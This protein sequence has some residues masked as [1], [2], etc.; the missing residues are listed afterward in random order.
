MRHALARGTR[1]AWAF[2]TALLAAVLIVACN[3][4]IPI[5]IAPVLSLGTPRPTPARTPD[6][7]NTTSPTANAHPSAPA[8]QKELFPW[9]IF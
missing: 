6:A 9:R 4:A 7:P 8:D 3:A 2:L 1:T 5:S